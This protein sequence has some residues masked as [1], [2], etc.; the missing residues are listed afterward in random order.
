[1][2]IEREH[3]TWNSKKKLK[4]ADAE[5]EAMENHMNTHRHVSSNSSVEF[6]QSEK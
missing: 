6:L 3:L 5:S 4:K 2:G 1:M